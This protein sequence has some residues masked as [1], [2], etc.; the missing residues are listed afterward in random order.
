MGKELTPID[1]VVT[2]VDMTEQIDDMNFWHQKEVEAGIQRSTN[3]QAF[4]IERYRDWGNFNYW[5]RGVEKNCPWVNKVFLV[6]ANERHLPAWLNL[7]NPKLRVVF[8][9]EFIPEELLPTF[10][11]TTIEMFYYRIPDLSDHF[12]TCNDDFFFLNPTPRER[13]FDDNDNVVQEIH[14]KPFVVQTSFKSDWHKTVYN[15]EVFLQRYMPAGQYFYFDHSHLQEP[16][17]KSF[18]AE[19]MA[20]HYKEIYDSLA[21]SHFRHKDNYMSWLFIDLLKLKTIKSTPVYHKSKYLHMNSKVRVLPHQDCEMICFNDTESTDNFELCR[22]RVLHLLEMKL[23]NKCSFERDESVSRLHPP[24]KTL[25][26]GGPV[27]GI[28]SYFPNGNDRAIRMHRFKLLLKQLDQYFKNVP[29]IIVAQNWNGYKP[30]EEVSSG[31]TIFDFSEKLGILRARRTLRQKFLETHYDHIIL[32]DDDCVISEN[33]MEL[34]GEL[35]ERAKANPKGFAFCKKTDVAN[36]DQ[37]D[38]P[39]KPSQLNLCVISRY[40]FLREDFPNTDPEKNAGYEDNIF[41]YLLHHK[42]RDL[43]FDIPTGLTHIHF[44][45]RK[46]LNKS[47]WAYTKD[48][49]WAT[50]SKETS[51][52]QDYIKE[53]KDL[54]ENVKF[55]TDVYGNL[56]E[57]IEN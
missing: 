20:K 38:E 4:A 15:N 27:I 34:C 22:T 6:V 46:F 33:G 56:K 7:D 40:I 54:P 5:F 57:K 3:G 44:K 13:F 8:H 31:L 32:F 47:T 25:G 14:K 17:V 19:I 30:T 36:P 10:N 29:I 42:Y 21:V 37:E 52:I 2:Y 11:S 28:C 23:P 26:G 35:L 24:V 51:K 55:L 18:E 16:R 39:Y 49:N 9:K 43:E 12:I 41:S 1:I 53:N 48:R 50:L 45:N